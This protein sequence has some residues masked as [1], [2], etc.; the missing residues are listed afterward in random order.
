M[1]SSDEL[2]AHQRRE[3]DKVGSGK[4]ESLDELQEDI[5]KKGGKV[6]SLGWSFQES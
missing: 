3:R 1:E 5:I 4:V 6:T 2:K